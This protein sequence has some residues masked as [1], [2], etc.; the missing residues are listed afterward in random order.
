MGIVYV[1]SN[2][3]GKAPTARQAWPVLLFGMMTRLPPRVGH[4]AAYICTVVCTVRSPICNYRAVL[5][6]YV[7]YVPA[8]AISIRNR[9]CPPACPSKEDKV[10][11]II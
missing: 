3:I 4:R 8:D 5:R 6:M 11:R 10:A 1:R 2:V 7:L 9:L